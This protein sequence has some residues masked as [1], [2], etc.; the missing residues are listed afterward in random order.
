MKHVDIREFAGGLLLIVFGL[1]VALYAASNYTIGAPARMGPGFFPVVLGWL[2]AGLGVII[3]L[4]AFRQTV[5]HLH[6]PPFRPRPFL[7]VLGA[8]LVFSLV[9]GRLGLVPATFALVCVAAFGESPYR[10]RRTVLLGIC[11]GLLAW[12]VFTLG[13]QMTLP[14]FNFPT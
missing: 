12:L 13:L 3:T 14:A 1:F 7:A 9:I 11:L 6:P 2:L 5:Q 8:I 4:L 10:L